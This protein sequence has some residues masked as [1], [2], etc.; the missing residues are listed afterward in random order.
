MIVVLALSILSTNQVHAVSAQLNAWTL[1]A[2]TGA[3]ANAA[4]INAGNV[5]VSA[6]TNRLFLAAVCMELGGPNTVPVIAMSLG[7]TTLTPIGSTGATTMTEQCYMGYLLDSQISTGP[8]ALTVSYDINGVVTVVTGA[9]IYWASYSGIDQSTPINDSNASTNGANNVT[10]GQQI[11]YLSD[12]V[13]FYVAANIGSPA[14]MMAPVGFSQRLA[15]TSN[16]HSSFV[17]QITAAPHAASNKGV[18]QMS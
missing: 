16:G 17:G 7:G 13:T 4:T 11:D 10:F 8:N 5:T 15:T 14:T 12:G 18:F 3:S 1:A 2:S 9:H 6:G